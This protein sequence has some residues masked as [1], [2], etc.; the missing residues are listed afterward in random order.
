[1]ALHKR[2]VQKVRSMSIMFKVTAYDGR[3]VRLSEVQWRH[4]LFFHPE[5]DGEQGK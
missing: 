3:K 2:R 4:I 1:M 5:V